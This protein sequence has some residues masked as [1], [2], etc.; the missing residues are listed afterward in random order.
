MSAEGTLTNFVRALRSADVTVSTAET[1]DAVQTVQLVGYADRAKLKLSLRSVLAKSETEKQTYDR[2][3][4]LFFKA[5]PASDDV[6][7][8][9]PDRSDESETSPDD[10][11][12]ETE[13]DFV[14]LATSGDET[15]IEM[16]IARA[17]NAAD[18]QDI[19]FSTQV[20]Y[21]AQKMLKAM[22]VEKMEKELLDRLQEHSEEGDAAAEEMME[23]RR[24]MTLRSIEFAKQQFDVFGAG[25]TQQFR[26]EFLA[27]KRITDMDRSDIERMKPLIEKLARRL[28]TKHSRRRRRKNRGQLDIR[29]TLRSNAGRDG[30]PF[31]VHWRQ[32]KKDRPKLVL[33]CDVSGSVAQYVRFLLL[34]LYCLRDVVPNL[35]SYAFS[36][37]LKDIGP[38]LSDDL[39]R[40]DQSMD[41][42]MKEVGWG[43]T[44]YGQALSD[45]KVDHWSVIDRQ[46]TII[47]LGDGR[48][49]YGDPR[50]DLFEEAAARAKRVVWLNPESKALWGTGDSEMHRYR[51]YCTVVSYLATLKHL[52]RA[53][54][55]VLMH[56]R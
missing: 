36:A 11:D 8:S 42:V 32:K 9:A 37:R 10:G 49:N 17:G 18:I 52:E 7:N 38:L 31:D 2:L 28:A 40:F 41:R 48:S 50:M 13:P 54:D 6:E 4:D 30:V 21:Y 35:H 26:D 5:R 53:V 1:L 39:G 16:A 14:S 25:A 12:S 34:F 27:D 29:K 43:S 46:T 45:L 24:Q 23:A 56:Y 44:D 19:R 20:G 33:I 51:S 3:F 55:D 47:V 22:G 15:K